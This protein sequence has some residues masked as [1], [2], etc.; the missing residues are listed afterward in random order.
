MKHFPRILALAAFTALVSR[1]AVAQD[2]PSLEVQALSQILPGTVQG[3]LDFDPA[4]GEWAGTNGIFVRYGAAV[5]TADAASVNSK[6]GE[7][8]A[9]GHVRIESGEQ[10]WVG[11]HVTYNFKTRLMQTE[12]FR[13][14]KSPVFAGGEGLAGDSSNRVYSAQGAYVTTDDFSDPAT[15]IRA[16]RIKLVPGQYVEMWNAVVWA[17]GVPVFYFP[18]YKRN[19]GPHA[20][21][22]NVTPGYR[23]SYGGFLLGTY[24][25]FLNDAVD[26]KIHT[27]YRSK[28]GP[29][30]GP[31]VN[32]HLGRWGEADVRYY[33]QYDVNANDSTNAIP[34]FGGMPKNRQRLYAGWQ[35]TPATN[36]NLKALVN[37]QSDPLV[38]RDF[39]AGEYDANP[40][41]NTFVEANQSWDNWSLD[42]LAAPR[43]NDFFSQIERLPDVKLTGFRQQIFDTPLYYDSES[44]IGW[45]R[46]WSAN[47]NST[48][49]LYPLTNGI[50]ADTGMRADTYHQVTLPWTF[51]HWLNVAPRVGGRFTY[52]SDR[53]NSSASDHEVYR[54][55]LNT[56]AE[57]SFKAAALWT[58]AKSS[59]FDVDG[60]RHIIEPSAN[61]IFVPN[62]SLS[63]LQLP[64]YDGQMAALLISPITFPDYNSV[65]SIDTMN[66]IRFGVR[67]ILQT[68]RD[69]QLD[70]LVNWNLMLDWRLD[71]QLD[72][73]TGQKQSSLND[74]YS[75]LAIRPRAWMTLE[76][77]LRYDTEAGHLNLSFHQLTFT[78]SDRWSWGIGHLYIHQGA[79]G[80]GAWDENNFISSTA[81]FRVSDNWGLRA[82]HNFNVKTGR[83]QQQYYSIYRDLRS[84][85]CALTFRVQDDLNS[86]PDYTVAIQISLKAMP[87]HHVGDDVVNP[88]RLVGE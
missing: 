74:L 17:E 45:F 2:A 12:S 43:V 48:N 1:S 24:T 52:Y 6:T 23:S 55:V 28:R 84:L 64:Q 51:F 33:Y 18:Y 40:Q 58:D 62:P 65:D 72:P 8:Q 29:G 38:L 26:G 15:R 41:P 9:D 56:G 36:L 53:A 82:Q 78:P 75:Q 70:D 13:T 85:T 68:K 5:L 79:W 60:L 66:V 14:G 20:G 57:I 42:A 63:P 67:N 22:F 81:Y 88:Y 54:G 44:S 86:Q 50:Y 76:E 31:D 61:Y 16:S 59:L 3:H 4:T 32:L 80:S 19:L 30:V 27:D 87:A 46:S 7:V 11:D 25:F 34:Q 49:A 47:V 83:L 35:A 71:R 73:L 77:Q 37:Y 69:G 21:N 39:F 10:V